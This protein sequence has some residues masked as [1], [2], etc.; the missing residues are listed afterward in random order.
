MKDTLHTLFLGFAVATLTFFC[1]DAW[2]AVSSHT[3]YPPLPS[4]V[5]ECQGKGD[6]DP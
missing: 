4:P 3:S 1:L 5:V 2:A 6:F